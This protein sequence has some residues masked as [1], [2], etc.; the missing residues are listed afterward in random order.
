MNVT[1]KYIEHNKSALET[2]FD[3]TDSTKTYAFYGVCG[4]QFKL[5]STVFE[6]K[7][8]E[9]DGYRSYLETVEVVKLGGI[10]Q[11]HPLAM[12]FV[13]EVEDKSVDDCYEDG[14]FTGYQLV[15]C[16]TGHVWLTIGTD[17]SDSYYPSFTFS[18]E[19][20]EVEIQ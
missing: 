3:K 19:I 12:V 6:A 13:R 8:D 2:Q 9:S 20:P 18:Y 1:D 17:Y 5:D 16:K 10:F 15:D 4:N 11:Y 14:D 7:E